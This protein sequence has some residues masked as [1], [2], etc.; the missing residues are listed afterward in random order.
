MTTLLFKLCVEDMSGK[1]EGPKIFCLAFQ[2][3]CHTPHLEGMP[4]FVF[5][6]S[7][8]QPQSECEA[9]VLVCVREISV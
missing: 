8:P 1:E 9:R 6:L 4:S 2:T 5:D 7:I 3:L